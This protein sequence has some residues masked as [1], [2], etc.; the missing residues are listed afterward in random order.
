LN[1]FPVLLKESC[2][3]WNFDESLK[4]K[5]HTPKVIGSK[6]DKDLFTNVGAP[7]NSNKNHTTVIGCVSASGDRLPLSFVSKIGQ[8]ISA[9]HMH[10]F[11]YMNTSNLRKRAR[12]QVILSNEAKEEAN[13]IEEYKI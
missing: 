5:E 10:M 7:K 11:D 1:K 6:D 12:P 13:I 3:V 9:D 4:C 8:T 2:R